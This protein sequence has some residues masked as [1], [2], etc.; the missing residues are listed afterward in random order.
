MPGKPAIPGKLP[1]PPIEKVFGPD[2][3]G[4]AAG[5]GGGAFGR[6]FSGTEMVLPQ[7]WHCVDVSS[8]LTLWFAPQLGQGKIMDIGYVPQGD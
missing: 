7:N 4:Y 3:S 5:A 6:K 2:I 1:A 8:S